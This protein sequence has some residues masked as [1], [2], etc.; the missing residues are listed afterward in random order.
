[1][2]GALFHQPTL[3]PATTAANIS[4]F[5]TGA[6]KPLA[7]GTSTCQQQQQALNVAAV[8]PGAVEAVFPTVAG[9]TQV[10]TTW[11]QAPVTTT[12]ADVSQVWTEMV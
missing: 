7:P 1:M 6:G 9:A 8:Q 3:P 12:A 4:A 5:Y 2:S 10:P 11:Q